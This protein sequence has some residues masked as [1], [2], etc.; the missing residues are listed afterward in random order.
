ML[1]KIVSLII[2]LTVSISVCSQIVNVDGLY[3]YLENDN[4]CRLTGMSLYGDYYSGDITIPSSIVS[5]NETYEVTQI[6]DYTFYCCED[7]T[8]VQIPSSVK[9]IG[10]GAFY[11]C[12]KLTNLT[13]P[14][15]IT[16]IEP[17]TFSYSG[18]LS[19]EVPC[20]VVS[21]EERAFDSCDALA[22]VVV[23][24]GVQSIGEY[25]FYG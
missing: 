18:L 17:S 14:G 9:R 19:F 24:D 5:E 11:G 21:I 8:S 23:P 6:D 13:L 2:L 3:Y 12:S 25:A 20:S 7:L 22:S 4:T 1:R 15:S 10:E 16:T